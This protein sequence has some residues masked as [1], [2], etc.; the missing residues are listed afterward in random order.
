MSGL[1]RA[2]VVANGCIAE[3]LQTKSTV[4]RAISSSRVSGENRILSFKMSNLPNFRRTT[5][6]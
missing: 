3:G 4:K 2:W 6:T 1:G 5:I